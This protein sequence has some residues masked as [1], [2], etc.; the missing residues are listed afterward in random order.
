M[1]S[2]EPSLSD[3]YHPRVLVRSL[4]LESGNYGGLLQAYALQ[5]ALLVLGTNPMADRADRFDKYSSKRLK[6]A[7][8]R[9]IV[10]LGYR[11]PGWL[12]RIARDADRRGV[13]TF[14]DRHIRSVPLYVSRQRVD[15]ALVDSFDAFI[16]GSDQVWRRRYADPR[17]NLFEF[18]EPDDGRP[19]FSY[20]A[21]FGRDDIDDYGAGLIAQTAELAQRLTAISVRE[22]SGVDLVWK[23]WALRAQQLIDPTFLVEPERYISL[24]S[25]A[26]DPQPQGRVIDYVLDDN[27]AARRTV[28][29]IMNHLGDASF[30]LL[31]PTPR[32]YWDFRRH[33]E[34]FRRPSVEAWLGAIGSARFVI[35][36]SFHGTALSIIH[37]VPFVS[38]LNPFRG[39]ARLESL[40]DLFGLEDRIVEAGAAIPAAVV[41]RSI[42]WDR[43]DATIERE[44]ERATV[45]L[46]RALSGDRSW[47]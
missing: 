24:A 11:N 4:P 46:C 42:D 37:H 21:S 3:R 38:I 27:P 25:T 14:A 1:V 20:A 35:T 26:V 9:V 44:R 31:P 22:A 34:Q 16:V 36:D 28:N 39:A 12:T 7:A 47:H 33:R 43:V 6:E 2:K 8:R 32:S 5:Q 45:Y 40:M 15:A 10:A 17:P 41:D 30:S 19:R 18:L 13:A 29:G 23:N